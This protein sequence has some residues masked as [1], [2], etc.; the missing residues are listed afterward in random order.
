[1]TTASTHEGGCLCGDVRFEI[2]GPPMIVHA[3][4]CTR[5][6]RR[7]GSVVGVNLW[8]EESRVRVLSGEI[9]MHGKHADENG[10]TSEGWRCAKCGFGLWT[11]YHSAPKG[12]LF[13]RVGAL[14]EPSTFPPDVHICTRS[15]QPWV[16]IPDDVPSFETYYD[17]KET[18]SADS[19]QRFKELKA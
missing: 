12:S 3:C 7:S 11:I 17:F 13:S 6:Q 16:T 5:C 8:I 15:K 2:S 4:H 14:D 19:R 10:Q 1:M 18:W 9:A